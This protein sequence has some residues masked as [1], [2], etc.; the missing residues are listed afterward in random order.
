MR[1]VNDNEKGVKEISDRRRPAGLNI[2]LVSGKNGGVFA[3]QLYEVCL[4]RRKKKVTEVSYEIRRGDNLRTYY[5][6]SDLN[7]TD[8]QKKRSLRTFHPELEP[9]IRACAV[10][11]ERISNT[12]WDFDMPEKQK[13][14]KEKRKR[15]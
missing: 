11:M 8:K 4:L 3:Y 12:C 10:L 13:S 6:F 14:K 2:V 15:R 1:H 9:A 7:G 5:G